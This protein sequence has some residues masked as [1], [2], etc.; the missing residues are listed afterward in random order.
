VRGG[1]IVVW[2]AVD[3]LGAVAR[4]ELV[5]MLPLRGWRCVVIGVWGAVDVLGAAARPQPVIMV[6]AAAVGGCGGGGCG[7]LGRRV[8]TAGHLDS[9][10]GSAVA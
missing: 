6:G 3:V 9:V 10:G 1:V 5:I 7:G 4:P 8:P 2:G